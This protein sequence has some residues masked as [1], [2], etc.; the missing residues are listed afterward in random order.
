[1]QAEVYWVPGLAA[2]RLAVLPRPRGG[3]WLGDEVRSLRRAGVEVLVSLLAPDEVV[4]LGLTEEAAGC[5][6]CG[7]EYAN[8]PIP[9]R[10]VPAAA[11]E[12]RALVRRLAEGKGVAVHCR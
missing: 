3:D 7:V 11:G 6:A 12:F 4:E 1:M 2:G 8:L 5:A 9:D 10:G